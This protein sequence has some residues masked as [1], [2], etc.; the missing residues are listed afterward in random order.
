M[1]MHLDPLALAAANLRAGRAPHKPRLRQI[2]DDIRARQFDT[3][4]RRLDKWLAAHSDDVEAVL[5]AAMLELR[6]GKPAQAK[7]HLSRCLELAP[8]FVSARIELAKL[9][10]NSHS[11]DE[12][13]AEAEKLLAAEN[14]NPL[15]RQ[16]QARILAAVGD[17]DQSAAIWKQLA[18]ENSDRP[19]C[20]ISYGNA[21]RAAGQREECVN[22]YRQAIACRRSSGL[23]W[24]GLANLKT[25]AF[26]DADIMAMQ[27]EAKRIDIVP[28]DRINLLFCLGKALEDRGDYAKS[29]EHYAK[30]NAARRQHTDYEW[31]EIAAELQVQ[32]SLF[33]REF[34]RT[35]AETGNR[36]AAPIFILGRPRSGSTLIEQILASHS[37][38]EGTSELPYIADFARQFL[39][40]ECRAHNLD[41]PQIL[42]TVDHSRFRVLGDEYLRR[43]RLH[44]KTYRPYFIDKSPANYHHIGLIHLMLPN[45]RIIDARRHPAACCLS[46][47]KHN[48]TDTNLRLDELGHVYRDYVSLTA[49][50]DLVLPG[51]IHRVIYEDMVANPET[52]IRRVLEYLGLPFEGACLR[53]HETKRPIRTP[54]SEQVRRPISAGAVEHWRH[55]EPWLGVLLRSLGSVL[56]AYPEVPEELQGM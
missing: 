7:A 36:T 42:S 25:Y 16:L 26:E 38:V 24:W 11:F 52:E 39:G 56:T 32:K 5:L 20:W 15:F 4:K 22:A 18:R 6:Q 43:T 28:E 17:D 29:F 21:L 51:R 23:A 50:F 53:F 9:L 8:A 35:R 48:Y 46:M 49:H 10:F 2:A 3:A 54:S 31:N 47:F 41:Y 14:N 1:K 44:R 45:A 37:E 27:E 30:A 40:Q 12:A 19:E 33:T 34:F 13:R 55:F